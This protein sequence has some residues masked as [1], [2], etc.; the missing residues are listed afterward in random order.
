METV[1]KRKSDFN[2]IKFIDMVI[3]IITFNNQKTESIV[4]FNI[5]T[6]EFAKSIFVFL[7]KTNN[8]WN[9]DSYRDHT[10]GHW[11]MYNDSK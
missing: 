7:K 6:S 10:I 1:F 2:N 11:I 8:S 4:S 5:L 9:I 3:R